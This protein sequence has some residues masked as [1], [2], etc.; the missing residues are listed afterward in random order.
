MT[1]QL[2]RI[3]SLSLLAAISSLAAAAALTNEGELQNV[4][5]MVC[6]VAAGGFVARLRPAE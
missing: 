2:E 3:I 6:A 5:W 1:P 4:F